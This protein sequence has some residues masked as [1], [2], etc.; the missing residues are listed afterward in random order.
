MPG[1]TRKPGLV[2]DM[3]G[4]LSHLQP[5]RIVLFG[6][7]AYGLPNDSSDVD[8]LV[9]MDY[10]GSGLEME[11]LYKRPAWRQEPPNKA[12]FAHDFAFVNA[13]RYF[14]LFTRARLPRSSSSAVVAVA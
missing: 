13:E 6:S 2:V 4:L 3:V 10:H 8:L 14:E 7:Y 1:S 9:V 5:Q 12:V 11:A